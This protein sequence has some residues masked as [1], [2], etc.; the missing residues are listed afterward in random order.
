MAATT[1]LLP[2]ADFEHDMYPD[3]F[4]LLTLKSMSHA[5]DGHDAI[6]GDFRGWQGNG[7]NRVALIET[8]SMGA[9][10]IPIGDI[11]SAAYAPAGWQL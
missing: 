2:I 11:K 7:H 1:G 10:T 8:R 3:T 9:Y 6:L 4:V 5:E